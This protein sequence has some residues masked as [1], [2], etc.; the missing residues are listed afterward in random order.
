MCRRPLLV[1]APKFSE[2]LAMAWRGDDSFELYLKSTGFEIILDDA[3]RSEPRPRKFSKLEPFTGE[4]RPQR[5]SHL[6]IRK[7][8]LK[9]R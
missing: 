1:S 9:V 4:T 5:M 7:I 8:K 6:R 2:L 3:F